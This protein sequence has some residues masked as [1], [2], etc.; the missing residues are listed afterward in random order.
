VLLILILGGL[1]TAAVVAGN[2]GLPPLVVTRE[3]EQRLILRLGEVQ[4]VTE[5]GLWWMIPF[6]DEARSYDSRWL[7]NSTEARDIQTKDGEQLRI[8]NYTVWRVH[9][10]RSFLE[11]FPG[12][13]TAAEQRIDRVVRDGVREVIGRHTLAEVLK[14]QRVAI[15]ESITETSREELADVG[16]EIADVRINRTELPANAEDSVYAR[17]VTERE[18]LARKNRA[19]GEERARAIRA[20]AEREAR[21]IVANAKRD[22]ELTRGKGDAEATRIYAEAYQSDSAF[23]A[24]VR[25]LEAYRKTI[26]GRTTIVLSPDTEFFRFLEDSGG[27]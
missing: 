2:Y 15:M 8:D 14:D 7:Y 12:D 20:E 13:M 11:A 24:F 3:G 4:H 19:G 22:A 16:I 21:I 10:P 25:S 27:E 23:Y 17:M 26:G 18:R 1:F 9:D 5:P 6:I